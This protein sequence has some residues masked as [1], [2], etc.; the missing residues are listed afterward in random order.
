M[1]VLAFSFTATNQTKM[2][3]IVFD[4]VAYNSLLNELFARFKKTIKEAQ[5]ESLAKSLPEEDWISPE[6]AKKLLPYK[7]KAKWKELR[8]TGAVRFSKFG[9]KTRYSKKSIL[10]FL[11]KNVIDLN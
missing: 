5:A 2:N 9:R 6:E 7:S 4:S 8:V 3:V 10:N 1:I 11:N